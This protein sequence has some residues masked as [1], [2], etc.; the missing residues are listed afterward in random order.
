[1]GI[2]RVIIGA[3]VATVVMFLIGAL[4]Y[5]T[6]L[7]SMGQGNLPDQQAAA[8]QSVLGAN[9]P[10]TGTYVVPDAS[11]DAQTVMYGRGPIATIHYNTDGFA[12]ADTTSMLG[13]LILYLVVALLMAGSLYAI[14]RQVHDFPSRARVVIGLVLMASAYIHLKM[15]VFYHHG[16]GHAIYGFIADVVTL[17]IGGLIIARFFLPYHRAPAAPADAPTEV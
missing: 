17:G 15:P 12:T 16:W 4:F 10:E 2:G 13:G 9:L 14:E 11:T 6:P 3:L 5:A 8:V 7:R 1:M